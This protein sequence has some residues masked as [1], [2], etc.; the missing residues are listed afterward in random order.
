[1]S[2]TNIGISDEI[3][4]LYD[5]QPKNSQQKKQLFKTINMSLLI[6][7]INVIFK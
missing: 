7:N 1:M 2:K 3:N 4:L 5:F 6:E